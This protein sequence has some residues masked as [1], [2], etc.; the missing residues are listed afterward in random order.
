MNLKLQHCKQID[1]RG[2]VSKHHLVKANWDME[3][4]SLALHTSALNVSGY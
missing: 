1:I 2:L 4:I 3:V